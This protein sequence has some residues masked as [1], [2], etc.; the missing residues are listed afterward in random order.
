MVISTH[1][2]GAIVGLLATPFC[3]VCV[4]SD[5]KKK[6]LAHMAQLDAAAEGTFYHDK[7][8]GTIDSLVAWLY[9][10]VEG[11]RELIRIGLRTDRDIYPIHKVVNHLRD[12]HNS[13]F[14]HLKELEQHI[15]LCFNAV[16]DCRAKLLDQIHLHQSSNS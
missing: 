16:N 8:L 12:N 6:Q 1:A 2:L 14:D 11:D 13:F 3:P 5:L 9:T 7:Y 10:A 4:P 15:C